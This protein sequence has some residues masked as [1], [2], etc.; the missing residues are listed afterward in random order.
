MSQATKL[1]KGDMRDFFR[2]KRIGVKLRYFPERPPDA[3]QSDMDV[4][5]VTGAG[6]PNV[7]ELR[8]DEHIAGNDNLRIIFFP[9]KTVLLGDRLPK[10]WV[11]SVLQKKTQKFTN[12]QLKTIKFQRQFIITRHYEATSLTL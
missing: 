4:S 3:P 2:L 1:T 9:V 5:K 11:L 7:Y 12:N 6:T 10:L 8:I